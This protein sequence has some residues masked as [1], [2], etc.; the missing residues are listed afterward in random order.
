MKM[1][2]R[3]RASAARTAPKYASPSTRNATRAARSMRQQFRP[4]TSNGAAV[5]AARG[6][7]SLSLA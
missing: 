3:A 5:R 4:G 6:D 7:A 2:R 1:E